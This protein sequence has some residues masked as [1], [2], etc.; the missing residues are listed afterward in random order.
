MSNVDAPFDPAQ[1]PGAIDAPPRPVHDGVDP[2]GVTPRRAVGSTL[3][4]RLGLSRFGGVYL[5]GVF[6]IIFSIWV[7]STF[8]TSETLKGILSD[9]SI[10]AMVAL[11]VLFP[12]A[13][14][15]YD[16]SVA[17]ML[18]LSA[19]LTAW[20]TVDHHMAAVPVIVIVLGVG[21]VVGMINGL[22]IVFVRV[23]SFIA[24]LG[25]SSVL[26]A[27]TYKVSND[28]YIAGINSSLGNLASPEPLG[29]PILA[30]Y[31]LALGV[32]IWYVLEHTPVG[33]RMYATGANQEASKL[34]G[35]ATGRITFC[36]LVAAS[37][38]ASLAGILLASQLSSASPDQGAGYLLPVFA[39]ALLG[40]T[41]IRPGKPNVVGT[42]VAIV[43][44][45]VGIKGLQLT[46][47]ANWVTLLFYGVALILAVS[48]ASLGK[49]RLA[50]RWLR[51]RS[52]GTVAPSDPTPR[53]P[54]APLAG[55]SGG[56][57]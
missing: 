9:Q 1:R 30:I 46:G 15:A 56:P 24:T 45:A 28:N 23:D 44:L 17:N 39:A 2:S 55:G 7:P 41:Q 40:T 22:L 48:A 52:S 18:G 37:V 51:K 16:L 57:T 47:A 42:I 54:T 6:I 11:G 50:P 4:G 53:G 43:L 3:I 20:L 5:I 36:A 38:I 33:R 31:V 8:L 34:A 26:L 27:I 21:A 49:R 13:V 14:G 29:I 10:T 32:F 25:M 35:V 12:L 19:M